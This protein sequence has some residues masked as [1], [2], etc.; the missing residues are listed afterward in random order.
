MGGILD[1]WGIMDSDRFGISMRS[2]LIV[3][4]VFLGLCAS[5][6]TQTQPVLP[7]PIKDWS[8]LV[9]INGDGNSLPLPGSTIYRFPDG[10]KG[11]VKH[12]FR[13]FND[14]VSDWTRYQALRLVVALPDE[15]EILLTLTVRG[16]G[17]QVVAKVPVSG[18]GEHELIIPREAFD[19]DHARSA[20][21]RG[22]KEI[23]I[24]GT[25]A[26]SGAGSLRLI[27]AAAVMAP[28]V[29]LSAEVSGKSIKSG[30]S[31]T[32]T[33]DVSNCSRSAQVIALGF[34]HYGW[35]A[36]ESSVNP[37]AV[38]LSPG[39]SCQVTVTVRVP[40]R[41]PPGGHE[42]QTLRALGNGSSVATL[43]L[44]TTSEVPHPFI[45]HTPK[46]WQEVRDK[47]ARCDWAKKA[48]DDYILQAEQWQVP[49]IAKPPENDPDDTYGPYLFKTMEEKGFLAAGISWQL[50]RRK[51][52]AE[53][54]RT[55]MLRLSDPKEGYP[56]TL[57]GCHQAVVQEGHFF[58][59]IV[60]AYDMTLDSGIYSPEEMEQI[61]A[62]FLILIGTVSI[63]CQGAPI[64]NWNLSE[65]GGALYCALVMGDLATAE[66][67]Y[68]GPAGVK[69]QLGKG[70][71]D[72]GWW[73]ECSISYNVWCTTEFTEMALALE[74][75]GYNFRDAWEPASYAKQIL[76]PAPGGSQRINL[77]G[78]IS[79]AGEDPK[80]RR[81]PFGMESEIW[82]EFHKPYRS[83]RDL[84]NSLIPFVD[85]RGVM[86][87]I[88]DSTENRVAGSAF[89]I[90]YYVYRDPAYAAMVRLGT[91]RS[92]LYGVEDLP[93]D[94]IV[95]GKDSAT[96]ANV[97]LTTLRS[98]TKDRPLR[99]QIS[100]S[101]HYG[102]HGWAHGHFDRTNLLA[103]N[104][105]GRSFYN[106]EMVWFGYEPFM[107]KFYVQ[108]SP[109]HNMV[110]VDRKNQE[111]M[112]GSQPLFHTGEAMQASVVETTA[113]WSFPPYGGMVYDYVPVKD[114]AGKTWREG[115][116]VPIP[117]KTPPYGTLS[118]YNEPVRQ[119]RLLVVTDDYVL[120]A[121]DLKSENPH[122]F[123]SL[124]QM[125]GF[126]GLE[127]PDKKFLRHDDQ[128]DTNPLGS[129]QFVTDANWYS[130][131]A[132]AVA[133]FRMLFGP[134]ADNEGTRALESEDGPLNIDY[135]SLWP[136][137]QE[138]MIGAT[139]EEHK[140]EKRL[141]YSVNGDG[142]QLAEGKFGSWILGRDKVDLPVEG[143]KELVLETHTELAQKPTLFWGDAVVITKEGK[144][145]P[146]SSL[147]QKR[148]GLHHAP[149]LGKDYYGGP[150]KLA[151]KPFDSGLAAEPAKN[152]E[153]G[154]I[155]VDLSG[156]G[157]VRFQA[158]IGGDYPLGDE[159]QRRKTMAIRSEKGTTA[160]FIAVIE[161][162]EGT[163]VVRSAVATGPESVRVEMTDGRVQEISFPGFG[164]E[165]KDLN[166]NLTESK[167]GK[168]LRQEKATAT[169]SEKAVQP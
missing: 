71:M 27:E 135:H 46:R 107:Y 29:A 103:L 160:R 154:R 73:Y 120:V 133:K 11:F 145:I 137:K 91:K 108:T 36:M 68:S 99:E 63:Q 51:E 124:F 62:T 57:R 55:F 66:R 28:G 6:L 166:V 114:F 17:E 106:P 79:N 88:N 74:P 139:P 147:P 56:K 24:A 150:I 115:R 134:D 125:K 98:Q 13:N 162:H 16:T 141:F 130:V 64:N 94:G 169:V 20:T 60:R 142:K 92:L 14:S 96:A 23:E 104:R 102:S 43:D 39:E 78:G 83:I 2:P 163:A 42:T 33:V 105:Y 41:I 100:A 168:I 159:A 113:R 93:K 146:V 161:P 12:G 157:G 54:V 143:V 58:Q 4:L 5:A 129:A 18:K 80:D 112:P 84:W 127:S 144:S 165:A 52:F 109:A 35:E 155:I 90:A 19:Y 95:L 158:E 136:Q 138:I 128:W 8:Q 70:A 77:N 117:E 164:G 156:V 132:P 3:S 26:G 121:D 45:V 31:A 149:P 86:L 22:V 151:G 110:I 87:G 49:E 50:T 122:D 72:D 101:V 81:R 126:L 131:S 140:T 37:D 40:E 7:L 32:Y 25:L 123:E 152:G 153:S 47:V 85:Y 44:V 82:G 48:A 89:D 67:F 167:E 34:S 15:K 97:G 111:S 65:V 119:R 9:T 1:W 76:L 10:P 118:G 116:F 61:N 30:E 21:W 69:D 59:N 148:E 53:K 38:K 75:F